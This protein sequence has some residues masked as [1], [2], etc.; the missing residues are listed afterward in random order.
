VDATADEPRTLEL[1]PRQARRLAGLRAAAEGAQAV[2]QAAQGAAQSVVGAY[3][4]ELT[5][6]LEQAGID[7]SAPGLGVAHDAERGT[8]E[9][10]PRALV[11]ARVG[12]N[13]TRR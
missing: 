9:V 3:Q 8:V 6:A 13:G 11:E 4:A 10:G 1:G 12:H 2:A 7:T 5:A